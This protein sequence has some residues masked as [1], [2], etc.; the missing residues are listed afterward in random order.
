MPWRLP[1]ELEHFRKTTTGFS[2]I[3]GRK[4]FQSLKEPLPN[5]TNI[6]LSRDED[7]DEKNKNIT[8]LNSIEEAITFCKNRNQEKFFFI[9]G[10]QIF[11]QVLPIVDKMII[12]FIDIIIEGDTYF[13]EIKEELWRQA[14]EVKYHNF[15]IVTYVR[16]RN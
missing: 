1:E 4:T 5:R 12:S 13:P 9:G 10:G 11:N 7:F 3:M 2:V 16:K 15:K 6:V 8:V 14:D